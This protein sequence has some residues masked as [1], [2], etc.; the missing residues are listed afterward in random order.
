MRICTNENNRQKIKTIN[1]KRVVTMYNRNYGGFDYVR[2]KSELQVS[3]LKRKLVI[4]N[5]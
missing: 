4:L 5:P 2:I 3:V 1:K